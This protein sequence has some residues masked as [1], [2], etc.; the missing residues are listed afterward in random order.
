MGVTYHPDLAPVRPASFT[1]IP[2]PPHL[3]PRQYP[4]QAAP[5]YPHGTHE[6]AKISLRAGTAHPR[7]GIR[8]K[9]NDGP[10]YVSQHYEY[11]SRPMSEEQ[12]RLH[13]MT[14][15]RNRRHACIRQQRTDLLHLGK[16]LIPVRS[17]GSDTYPYNP[18][19]NF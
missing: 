13:L 2:T 6:V 18:R 3:V 4:V 11:V 14:R 1:T 15:E 8:A 16:P 17:L 19:Y 7:L 12:K 9:F 10:K 5:A